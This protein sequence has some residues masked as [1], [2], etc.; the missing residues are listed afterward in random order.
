MDATKVLT[1]EDLRGFREKPAVEPVPVKGHGLLH[2]KGLTSEEGDDWEA[3][4]VELA[5]K[6]KGG[7]R[8]RFT[9]RFLVRALCHPDGKPLYPPTGKTPTGRPTWSD[10][11]IDQ[12]AALPRALADRCW[13]AASALSRITEQDVQELAKN[14]GGAPSAASGSA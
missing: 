8:R 14:S 7:D 6:G 4:Q 13:N 2:V 5:E 9:A 11:Q 3:E 1:A 10:E 12:V